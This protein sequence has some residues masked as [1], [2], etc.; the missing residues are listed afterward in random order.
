MMKLAVGA[1]YKNLGRVRIL[2]SYPLG[3]PPRCG[4]GLRRWENQRR[5]SSI[6]FYVFITRE[7][8]VLMFSAAFIRVSVCLFIL[9]LKGNLVLS[10]FTVS[11]S[12]LM[13]T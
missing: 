4:V 1:L 8:N 12:Y 13:N 6:M 7:C 11:S 10:I 3:T 9:R 5:L 2:G